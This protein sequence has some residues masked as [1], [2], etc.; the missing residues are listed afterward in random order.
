MQTV[1]VWQ[2]SENGNYDCRHVLKDHTAEVNMMSTSVHITCF[3]IHAHTRFKVFRL[4]IIFLSFTTL[5]R[6]Y[7]IK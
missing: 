3:V 2:G 1:R 4:V 7:T 6:F 5:L